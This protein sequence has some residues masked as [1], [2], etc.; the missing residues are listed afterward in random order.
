MHTMDVIVP[1]FNE[2][3]CLDELF[4]RLLALRE[5]L[6][7]RVDV[8]LLFVNDGSS[9]RSLEL[10]EQLTSGNG[11]VRFVSFTRNF[12][13][14]LAVSAGLDHAT[15]D[16]VAIVDADLQDPPEVIE[17]MLDVALTGVDV[18]YGQRR[19]RGGEGF[20]KKMTASM[21]YRT[22]SFLCDTNIPVDTGDFRVISRRVVDE[23]KKMHESQRFLRGMIPWLGF[24]SSA[25]LYDRDERFA[26]ETKYPFVKMVRFAMD[27]IFS[28]SRKPLDYA[29]YIGVAATSIATLGGLYLLYLKIFTEQI[30]PGITAVILTVILMGG[31][32]VFI[33]GVIGQY[34]ARIFEETK[35]RPLYVVD[36]YESGSNAKEAHSAPST[37]ARDG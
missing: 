25:F 22:L 11:F 3:D 28:F 17:G 36:R 27:A 7:G 21:F 16:F 5:R 37:D 26:G 8:Q 18:V 34:I 30:V 9:D 10:L 19:A 15:A 13:H 4:K 12:G 33:V 23:L 1:I 2:E 31:L 14:Q 35:N 6:K 24:R 32:Q 20:F 29:T